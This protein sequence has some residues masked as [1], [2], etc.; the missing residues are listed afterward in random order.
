MKFFAS[1]V[2]AL[3]L[4]F[5][6]TAAKCGACSAKGMGGTLVC[7]NDGIGCGLCCSTSDEC[8][9]EANLGNCPHRK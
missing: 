5:Q 1:V 7:T 9:I 3:S 2:I 6:F 4:I 8:Q